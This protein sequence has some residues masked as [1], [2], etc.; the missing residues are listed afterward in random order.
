M[1]NTILIV[2]D[3]R[4]NIDALTNILSDKY[5]IMAAVSGENAIKVM[6]RK[7]PD[8][9]LLDVS[10]PGIDGFEVLKFMKEH[11]ELA[12][13]PVIFITGGSDVGAEEKGLALGAVDYIKKPFREEIIKA[14]VRNHLE[15]STYRHNLELLVS[16]RTKQLE[17]SRDAVI[18]G[19]SLMS[20]IHDKVTGDHIKRIRI[21]TQILTN[22]ML[23]LYPGVLNPDLASLI[24]L[25]SPLHDVGKVGISDNILKKTGRL[26]QEEF[27]SMKSH[28]LQGADILR[29]TERFFTDDKGEVQLTP[30]EYNIVKNHTVEGAD[31]LRKTENFLSDNS[32]MANLKVAIEIAECHHEKFDGSGYPHGLKG[33]EIPLSARIVAIADV[34]DALKSPRQYKNAFTHEEAVDI[35]LKGDGRT[36]PDHFDPNI[37]EVFSI[38]HKDFEKVEQ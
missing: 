30:D 16:E 2:D 19:M 12:I 10:M 36:S 7:R 25:Y 18:M 35:I 38:V 26:T 23:E 1:N 14:K 3:V 31:I 8:L 37:L 29:E 17:A 9:V 15:L 28:T 24:V 32:D 27:D 6:E 13:I 21:F 22:K 33:E 11:K 5:K 34:Y 20:D 4:L